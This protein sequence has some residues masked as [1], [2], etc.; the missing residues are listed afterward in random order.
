M[1]STDGTKD[2]IWIWQTH[3]AYIGRHIQNGIFFMINKL[4]FA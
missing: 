2:G 3:Y 1:S 4:A